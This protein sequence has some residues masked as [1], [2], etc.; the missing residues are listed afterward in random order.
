MDLGRILDGIP[1]PSLSNDS[2][3][4]LNGSAP[5][6]SGDYILP[7]PMTDYQT[8]LYD[9]VISAHY[10]DI[11]QFFET[12]EPVM[13]ESLQTLYTNS[14]LVSNHPYLLVDH[15]L[16]HNLLLKEVPERLASSSGKFKVLQNIIEVSKNLKLNIALVSRAGK[17]IDLLEAFILGKL[18]NYRRYSGSYLR[19][20]PD[21]N[22]DFSTIHLI[23]S[24]EF[25]AAHIDD[26]TKFDLIIAFDLSFDELEPHIIKIRSQSPSGLC[27][28][29]RLI[30]YY[31]VEHIVY[32]RKKSNPNV[33]G[34][35]DDPEYL[36][37]VLS[38]ISVLRG[39]VGLIPSDLKPLYANNL[40]YLLKW[41][42][43]PNSAWLLP[44]SPTIPEYTALDV[45]KSLLIE[46]EDPAAAITSKKGRPDDSK[47]YYRV[48]RIKREKEAP[49]AL[50]DAFNMTDTSTTLDKDNIP[51]NGT[52]IL[53]HKILQKLNFLLQDNNLKRDEL[54]SLRLLAS[55]RQSKLEETIEELE[56]HINKVAELETKVKAAEKRSERFQTDNKNK[57]EKVL[58]L[59][60][61]L[62]ESR[63]KFKQ[64]TPEQQELETQRAR[65]A[66]LEVSLKKAERNAESIRSQNDYLTQEYQ[67]AS[68]SAA[69]SV[70]T[71]KALE[72]EK[73]EL[74]RKANGEAEKL[75]LLS[76]DEERLVK[77]DQIK[78]LRLKLQMVEEHLVRVLDIEKQ[79]PTGRSRYG[80]GNSRTKSP[81][82]IS[83]VSS[84]AV[85]GK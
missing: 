79:Q 16:P 17:T 26:S 12:D 71:I 25:G 50:E 55:G 65:I 68:A 56:K 85:E 84:P 34:A 3:D 64:G 82:G 41:F 20:H 52:T 58:Q 1:E 67:R 15:Y 40:K 4:F 36:K 27:S 75:R 44:D 53:T 18:V 35:Q 76:F 14:Q 51:L 63:E 38:A 29:I 33:G 2:I 19:D 13:V 60:K 8:L 22:P 57:S 9:Q 11:L 49:V 66:E 62:E 7:V 48:K 24:S 78:E 23:P 80:R 10:S 54:D 77:N 46:V 74:Q 61:D 37:Q 73:I 45:E 43:N 83:R 72:A 39:K 21:Q 6:S 5:N 59:Q 47:D 81:G 70:Q 30:P 28:I 31:S 69:E 42:K 32:A